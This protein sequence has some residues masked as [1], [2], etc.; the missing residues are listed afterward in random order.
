VDAFQ[1][2]PGK[3]NDGV[4][5]KF[6]ERVEVGERPGRERDDHADLKSTLGF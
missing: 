1:P 3:N 2:R 6:A 4:F 5:G